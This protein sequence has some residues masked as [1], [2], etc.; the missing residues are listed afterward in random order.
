[1][2]LKVVSPILGFEY[3]KSMSY[4]EIDEYFSKLQKEGI[5]FTLID[6]TKI[7]EY[8]IEIPDSYSEKLKIEEGDEVSV[9]AIMILNSDIK[10][11]HI[12]FM[13]PI[14]IN[15]TKKL[16]AQVALDSN[17]YSDYGVYEPIKNYL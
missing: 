10:E 1:M 8:D 15:K 16:L 11:S 5:S 14:V 17:I 3:I 4:S 13:A 9:Y 6:P 7:R 12:N 2:E